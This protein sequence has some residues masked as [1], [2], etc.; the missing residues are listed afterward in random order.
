MP[1]VMKIINTSKRNHSD[2]SKNL[3]TQRNFSNADI[4]NSSPIDFDIQRDREKTLQTYQDK[5]NILQTYQDRKKSFPTFQIQDESEI[6]PQFLIDEIKQSK[7]RIN[8]EFF[9]VNRTK[10]PIIKQN[11]GYFLQI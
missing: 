2:S 7:Y 10:Y 4:F 1:N 5:Q 8:N 11:D 3:V 9:K 6:R